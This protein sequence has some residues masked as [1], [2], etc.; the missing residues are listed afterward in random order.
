MPNGSGSTPTGLPWKLRQE[1]RAVLAETRLARLSDQYDRLAEKIEALKRQHAQ[2]RIRVPSAEEINF[3]K[4]RADGLQRELADAYRMLAEKD[5]ELAAVK[6]LFK[7]LRAEYAR[8]L[9]SDA[10]S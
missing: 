6:D 2:D 4:V 10:G 1:V 7:K 3:E 5:R 8:T 9:C